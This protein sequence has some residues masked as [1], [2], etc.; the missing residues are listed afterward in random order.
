MFA[1]KLSIYKTYR[2]TCS[3]SDKILMTHQACMI[4]KDVL[5]FLAIFPLLSVIL[6]TLISTYYRPTGIFL[7]LK[8]LSCTSYDKHCK[9][10]TGMVVIWENIVL[11][12]SGTLYGF[13]EG[14]GTTTW[15]GNC[16]LML[17]N[18]VTVLIYSKSYETSLF[19]MSQ[20]MVPSV[21]ALS[22]AHW[23]SGLIETNSSCSPRFLKALGIFFRKLWKKSHKFKE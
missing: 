13:W 19:S 5:D 7:L 23:N 18:G 6:A 20:H 22:T 14:G 9:V 15:C 8:I 11:K 17:D 21:I 3:D 4:Q 1:Y 12:S 16:V 2:Q 10:H